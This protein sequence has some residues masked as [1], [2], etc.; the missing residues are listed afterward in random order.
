MRKLASSSTLQLPFCIFILFS[1]YK[2][3]VI[4]RDEEPVKIQNA[5]GEMSP[6]HHVF[7]LESGKMRWK[8]LFDTGN[9]V[10]TG[11]SRELLEELDLLPDDKEEVVELIGGGSDTYKTRELKLFIRGCHFRAHGLV[12]AVAKDTNL[13]MGTDVIEQLYDRGYTIGR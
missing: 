1:G 12:G 5:S 7:G 13:L 3:Y 6:I 4:S 10:G 8:V 9:E 11:I 2:P